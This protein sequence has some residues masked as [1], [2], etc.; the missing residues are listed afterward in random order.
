[1]KAKITKISCFIMAL[2]VLFSTFS[3]TVEKHFCGEF[4]VDIAY[5]GHAENCSGELT[6]DNCEA[7]P[8]NKM[9]DCCKDEVQKFE[10]QDDLK[11]SFNDFDLDQ[12][13]ILVAFSASFT[14]VF[15]GSTSGIVSNEY[16][17]PPLLIKDRVILHEVFLI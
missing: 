14:I 16:Y 11:L 7:G 17:P 3:F 6:I 4:L 1:M 8:V 5:F 2:F 15:E 10:G 9:K 13:L 12:Q